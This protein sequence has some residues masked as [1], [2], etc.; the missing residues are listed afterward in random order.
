MSDGER[1]FGLHAGEGTA[2]HQVVGAYGA[3][4]VAS[5][6]SWLTI[7]RGREDRGHEDCPKVFGVSFP[8]DRGVRHR[9]LHACAIVEDILSEFCCPF[10]DGRVAGVMGDNNGYPVVSRVLFVSKCLLSR[11]VR[12]FV[13]CLSDG[14]VFVPS[15]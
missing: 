15:F 12:C 2:L 14:C 3:R 11:N 4:L 7:C 6:A 10:F 1:F 13:T 9:L 5:V 8:Q